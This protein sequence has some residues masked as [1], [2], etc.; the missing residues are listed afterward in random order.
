MEIKAPSKNK[1]KQ[2]I[3]RVHFIVQLQPTSDSCECKPFFRD[4]CLFIRGG[5]F[6]QQKNY[7]IHKYKQFS[8]TGFVYFMF[9]DR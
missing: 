2:I 9:C 5:I 1:R 6:K 8:P 4:F 3:F 7:A